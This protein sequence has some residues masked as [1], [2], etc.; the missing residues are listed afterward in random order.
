MIWLL[1]GMQCMQCMTHQEKNKLN[2]LTKLTL[3]LRP[4]EVGKTTGDVG[5]KTLALVVF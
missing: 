4:A 2:T 5:A 3:V 1:G